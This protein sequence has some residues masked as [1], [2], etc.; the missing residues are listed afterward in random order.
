MGSEVNHD[1]Q[2]IY[3]MTEFYV[4]YTRYR[5]VPNPGTHRTTPATTKVHANLTRVLSVPLVGG[6]V[7]ST[8]DDTSVQLSYIASQ[9]QSQ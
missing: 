7:A 9:H 3:V 8:A 6:S 2:R 5:D 1:R 4:R